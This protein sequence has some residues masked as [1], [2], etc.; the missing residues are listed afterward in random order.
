MR[1]SGAFV[2]KCTPWDGS[3]YSR[4]FFVFNLLSPSS[5][6]RSLTPKA[7]EAPGS[8]AFMPPWP[9]RMQQRRLAAIT[10]YTCR[11][12]PSAHPPPVIEIVC[13]TGSPSSNS[14]AFRRAPLIARGRRKCGGDAEIVRGAAP[15]R[16]LSTRRIMNLCEGDVWGCTEI[17]FVWTRGCFL[18]TRRCFRCAPSLVRQSKI[19]RALRETTRALRKIAR[20]RSEIALA[21][22]PQSLARALRVFH[23][24]AHSTAPHTNISRV[25][26]SSIRPP[27]ILRS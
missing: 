26:R 15:D 8:A 14:Q 9:T 19:T 18:P 20:A 16:A 17:E 2:Q 11:R 23:R 24:T 1:I 4:R 10:T 13:D 22:L 12:E 3:R 5:T 21:D 25:P 6:P 7:S 27:Y